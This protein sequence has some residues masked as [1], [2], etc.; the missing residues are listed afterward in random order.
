[1]KT[2]V[3]GQPMAYEDTGQGPAVLL[4]HSAQGSRRM[5]ESQFRPLSDAGFRVIAPDLRASGET[6]H[7]GESSPTL[8]AD[9]MAALLHYLGI[10]R[11]VVVG[12]G[13]GGEVLLEML[14]R[15]RRKVAGACFL[16]SESAPA[17]GR[18]P[19][20]EI[21]F[22]DLPALIIGEERKISLRS[23]KPPSRDGDEVPGRETE[24]SPVE[25]N[26]ALLGFLCGLKGDNVCYREA[27]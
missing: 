9:A 10:G 4:L 24:E 11:V 16:G 3:N 22:L 5:W 13:L 2:V 6:A 20:A 8:L 12:K 25:L 21:A 27:T 15:H 7:P 18:D 19:A 14:R 17:G 1:M 26:E 23:R